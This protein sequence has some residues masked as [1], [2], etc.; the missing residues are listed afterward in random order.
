MCGHR[1]PVNS[2]VCP[3]SVS[4]KDGPASVQLTVTTS[5]LH[6]LEEDTRNYR[7]V[8]SEPK[9]RR[10]FIGDFVINKVEKAAPGCQR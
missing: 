5:H 9:S 8:S 7:H 3:G 6:F 2:N 1:Q 4:L 10:L